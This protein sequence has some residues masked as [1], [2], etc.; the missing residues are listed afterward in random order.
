MDQPPESASPVT[1]PNE[2]T[3]QW[4]A[5]D[6]VA[7]LT[8]IAAILTGLA[9]WSWFPLVIA[10][11]VAALYFLLEAASCAITRAGRSP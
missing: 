11:T 2:P 10:A 7:V 4:V 1:P 9:W 5:L 3:H 6:F 8:V